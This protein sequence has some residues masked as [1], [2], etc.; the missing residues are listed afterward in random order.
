MTRYLVEF[1]TYE[2]HIVEE[3]DLFACI[4]YLLNKWKRDAPHELVHT[5][6]AP[7]REKITWPPTKVE[8]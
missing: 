1:G 4:K 8:S 3:I 2:K 5:K 7:E 6:P